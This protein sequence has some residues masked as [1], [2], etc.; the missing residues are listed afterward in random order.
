MLRDLSWFDSY[1]AGSSII[2]TRDPR[3]PFF[4]DFNHVLAAYCRRSSADGTLRLHHC[5]SKISSGPLCATLSSLIS[6]LASSPQQQQVAADYRARLSSRTIES[7][8]LRD[9][10]RSENL[11][12]CLAGGHREVTAQESENPSSLVGPASL[13]SAEVSLAVTSCER[14]GALFVMTAEPERE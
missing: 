7:D 13:R 9:L 4:S 14:H 3:A 1:H 10:H 11:E 12:I 8:D 2:A 6:K 5:P